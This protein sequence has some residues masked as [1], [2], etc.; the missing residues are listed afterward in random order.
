M[1]I[2]TKNKTVDVSLLTNEGD[3]DCFTLD[4]EY[5]ATEYRKATHWEPEEGN[6]VFIEGYSIILDEDQDGLS[7]SDD[8]DVNE[9]IL[10]QH[11]SALLDEYFE[12]PV[13]GEV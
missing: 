10:E 2:R 1:P 7:V 4:V 11:K 6:E 3:Y 8:Q 5:Y 12:E 9:A 13:E